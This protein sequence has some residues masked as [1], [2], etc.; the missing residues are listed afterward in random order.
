MFERD[1]PDCVSFSDE[2]NMDRR[3]EVILEEARRAITTQV[4]SLDE[5]RSRTGL[6]LAAATLSGSFLG[7]L[8]A[9]GN[10]D[11]GVAGVSAVGFY[12]L[13]VVCCLVVLS[14][15]FSAWTTVTSPK[16]LA[17]DWL[18]EERPTESM[19][20]FLAERLEDHYEANKRELD[21]LYRWFQGATFAVGLEV[22]L[23]IAQLAFY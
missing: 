9:D 6:L 10:E 15:R 2:E 14:V 7:S 1:K 12:L 3:V 17:Q 11:F 20:R 22:I 19:Q 5:L 21:K 13:A 4:S 23:G 18:D 8:A 16:V